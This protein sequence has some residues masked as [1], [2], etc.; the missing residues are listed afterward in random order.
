M[1]EERPHGSTYKSGNEKEFQRKMI[2]RIRKCIC[3]MHMF[4]FDL[5]IGEKYGVVS[6]WFLATMDF[7]ILP[8]SCTEVHYQIQ[9][10]FY[11]HGYVV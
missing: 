2:I 5:R 9:D 10:L 11:A 8:G 3:G 7:T 6:K 1:E 4:P